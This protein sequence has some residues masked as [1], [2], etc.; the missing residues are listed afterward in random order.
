MLEI[1]NTDETLAKVFI[2]SDEAWELM[3]PQTTL[4]IV[5]T[6]DASRVIDAAILSKQTKKL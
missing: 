4:I 5:D 3:T 2:N 1:E 6:S